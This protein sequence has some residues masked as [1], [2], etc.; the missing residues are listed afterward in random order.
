MGRVSSAKATGVEMEREI[1][2]PDLLKWLSCSR[3]VEDLA[4]VKQCTF[5]FAEDTEEEFDIAKVDL[6]RHSVLTSDGKAFSFGALHSAWFIERTDNFFVFRN[7][8]P[9]LAR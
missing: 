2:G 4:A 1:E 9:E 3:S 6:E 7:V 8:Y 5:Y